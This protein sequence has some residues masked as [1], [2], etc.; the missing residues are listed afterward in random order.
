MNIEEAKSMDLI[1][2]YLLEQN[3][4]RDISNFEIQKKLFPN[5][6]NEQVSY[7]LNNIIK[8]GNDIIKYSIRIEDIKRF[9]CFVQATYRTRI[10]I[11]KEN[12]FVG[13]FEKSEKTQK[14]KDR[15]QKIQNKKLE[16]DAKL[17]NWQ[18]K[19]FWWFFFF[20]LVGF[21]YGFYDFITDQKSDKSLEIIEKSNQQLESELSKLRTLVLDQKKVDS[22]HN[23]RTQTYSLKP[24]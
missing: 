2:R 19:T 14:E 17:S 3:N 5:E 18:I 22:L 24:R 15:L 9:D 16:D 12:G 23:S 4:S 21:C 8:F 11:E 20:S 10:F 6:D 7:L 13:L 1:L